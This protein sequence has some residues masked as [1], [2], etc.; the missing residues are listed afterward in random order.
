MSE[1]EIASYESAFPNWDYLNFDVTDFGIPSATDEFVTPP[2]WADLT[3]LGMQQPPFPT[4]YT[5]IPSQP[6]F[7]CSTIE[8]RSVAEVGPQKHKTA[9]LVLNTLKS[10]PLMMLR[11]DN[12]PPFV[13]PHL[14]AMHAVTDAE[15]NDMEPLNN[16]IS[17][18]HMVNS[19]VT[20]SRKLF[21]RNVRMECE[22]FCE[23]VSP[24][25]LWVV[26]VLLTPQ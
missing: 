13:H 25:T 7:I 21:W 4:S 17:L 11:R 2:N 24:V 22:R 15:N 14:M 3:G 8:R 5:S 16:C 6:T 1:S 19:G 9:N 10:Y 23:I 20:G 26:E 12:L 18:L